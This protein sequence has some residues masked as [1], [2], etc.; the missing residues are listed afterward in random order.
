MKVIHDFLEHI[1]GGMVHADLPVGDKRLVVVAVSGGADSVALLRSLVALGYDCVVAH[2]NF[3]LRGDESMRD[4]RF[5][6]RLCHELGVALHVRDFDVAA[7]KRDHHGVSTEMACRTLRYDWFHDL[8][9]EL[10]CYHVAVAHHADD[11]VETFFIN[12]LRGTG[13]NGLTGMR[14]YN[15]WTRIVRPMLCLPR[16]QVLQYLHVIGQDYV[17]DST[18]LE[19]EHRRN[20]VRNSILPA[21]DKSFTDARRHIAATMSHL[22][23]E[24]Q[25]LDYLLNRLEEED[26]GLYDEDT[27]EWRYIKDKLL[28]A[29]QPGMLLYAMIR[30]M[31]F[32]RAQCEQAMKAAPGAIFTSS[33]NTL[34]I[35]RK[36][37]TVRP[38]SNKI[39]SLLN[40]D[41][42]VIDL[43]QK[44]ALDGRLRIVAPELPFAPSLVDGKRRV[45]FSADLR[46]CRR[47]A[48]RHWRHGDRFHP[49]GMQG[50]KLLSDLF[51]DLKLSLQQKEA[52]WLLEA[53]G[54]IVWVLGHRSAQAFVVAPGATDYV[55]LQYN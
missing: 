35:D 31:G 1:K 46:R 23:D 14:P 47:V 24:S 45:A 36:T 21:L 5:V 44:Q 10:K 15:K 50:T 9:A 40:I 12:L 53:D 37:F 28:E 54:T 27:G 32:N 7:Y 25:L 42:I 48:L 18:N 8:A 38:N 3:H 6:R 4:E 17:T 51:C 19:N 39:T 2:C 52:V 34:T 43:W 49:F 16:E 41:E 20:R 26:I 22:A 13:I 55:L 11:N 29:P 33:T 30:R